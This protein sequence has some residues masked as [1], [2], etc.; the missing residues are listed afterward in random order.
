[1]L[2]VAICLSPFFPLKRMDLM[3]QKKMKYRNAIGRIE[4][5]KGTVISK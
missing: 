2:P 3:A 1:M 4:F 5:I